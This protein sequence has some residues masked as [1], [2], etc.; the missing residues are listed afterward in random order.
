MIA[1]V[2]RASVISLSQ[3]ELT[4]IKTESYRLKLRGLL[5]TGKKTKALRVKK[6]T[7][8]NIGQLNSTHFFFNVQVLTGS[9]KVSSWT[10]FFK[11]QKLKWESF[12]FRTVVTMLT[13]A[14]MWTMLFLNGN[15][16]KSHSD[17]F[18]QRTRVEWHQ[19]LT[20][21]QSSIYY[22]SRLPPFLVAL[23]C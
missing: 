14:R 3:G 22:L 13:T 6:N 16:I 20:I 17:I 18:W 21:P 5:T 23:E 4:F 2:E 12:F 11:E 8:T 1:I 15:F 19:K 9:K 10:K 7:N